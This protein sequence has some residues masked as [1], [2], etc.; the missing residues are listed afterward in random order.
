MYATSS[1]NYST[2]RNANADL[3]TIY[4]Y[5]GSESVIVTFSALIKTSNMCLLSSYLYKFV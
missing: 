2:K 3:G 5:V 4:G 1:I